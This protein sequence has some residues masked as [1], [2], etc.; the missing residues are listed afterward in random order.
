MRN[1]IFFRLTL[2]GQP[3]A[4]EHLDIVTSFMRRVREMTEQIGKE[5]DRP[6][7][8]T[9]RLPSRVQCCQDI[10]LATTV[11]RH[12]Q[13]SCPGR[14]QLSGLQRK[15]RSHELGRSSRLRLCQPD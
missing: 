4:S 5:R 1:P 11:R 10:G 3:V 2:E 14:E 13:K 15:K 7:L 9:S 6:L 8:V 12:S